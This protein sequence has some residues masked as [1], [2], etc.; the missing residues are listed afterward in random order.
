MVFVDIKITDEHGQLDSIGKMTI[1]NLAN[2]NDR[3]YKANYE[4]KYFSQNDRIINKIRLNDFNRDLGVWELIV[5]ALSEYTPSSE[6]CFAADIQSLINE[7]E[8]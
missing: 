2:H 3:P 5:E 7:D 6:D 4:I 1:R 8:G